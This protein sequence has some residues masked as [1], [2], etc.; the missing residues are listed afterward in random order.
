MVQY[1]LQT[2]TSHSL[3]TYVKTQYFLPTIDFQIFFAVVLWP[4]D[5]FDT[6]LTSRNVSLAIKKTIGN[7]TSW[8]VER[9]M[10]FRMCCT[11]GTCCA[12]EFSTTNVAITQ[13][14]H[15]QGFHI[16]N[17]SYEQYPKNFHGFSIRNKS[18]C[19]PLSAFDHTHSSKK[20][21]V[22]MFETCFALQISTMKVVANRTYAEI[23]QQNR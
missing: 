11:I 1:A 15:K 4:S 6:V 12:L 17:L 5:G 16:T 23:K 10:R 18:Q 13:Q 2:E 7:V 22:W 19:Q 9:S 21:C 3:K 14:K 20:Q 8:S